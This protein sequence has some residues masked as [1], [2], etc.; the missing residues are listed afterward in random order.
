MKVYNENGNVTYI[1]EKQEYKNIS[2]SEVAEIEKWVAENWGYQN[3]TPWEEMNEM[4]IESPEKTA[5]MLE[6]T[7]ITIKTI[8]KKH[9]F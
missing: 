4:F 9:G 1:N 7:V 5:V 6:C 3:K 2:F 8:L